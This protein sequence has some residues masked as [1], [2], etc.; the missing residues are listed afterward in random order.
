MFVVYSD[1]IPPARHHP[2][3]P[4]DNNPEARYYDFKAQPELIPVVLED[5]K[6]W[7]HYPAIPR[8][9]ELFAWLNGSESILESNDCG[10]RPPRR[11][12]AAPDIVRQVFDSDP[13]MIHG[14]LTILFRDLTGNTSV[15]TVAGLKKSVH[16]GMRDCTDNFPSCVKVGEWVHLFTAINEEGHAVFLTFWA[17]GADEAMMMENL[18][19]TVQL[20]HG[21]LKW[22]SAF[23]AG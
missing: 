10:L 15:P 22:I 20:I 23:T 4:P 11:D 5:F 8:F 21:C 6:P 7:V 2:W 9:Y 3:T 18:L 1:E 17:W 14:R 12:H 19:C 13:I 16:D